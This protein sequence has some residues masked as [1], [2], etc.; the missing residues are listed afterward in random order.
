[1]RKHFRPLRQ[2]D[3]PTVEEWLAHT[4]YSEAEKQTIRDAPDIDVDALTDREV[5]KLISDFAS[6]IKMEWYG[7]VKAPR[8]IQGISPSLKKMLGPLIH[9]AELVCF[10]F[11]AFAKFV[12]V[13][14]RAKWLAEK[15]AQF[16]GCKLAQSDFSSFEQS[17]AELQLLAFEMPVFEHMFQHLDNYQ[18]IMKLLKMMEIGLATL[19]FKWMIVIVSAIRKSGTT[20]TSFS[21][22]MGNLLI[23]EFLGHHLG[24]GELVAAF[25]GDDGLFLYSS[26]RFPTPQD[27]A[28]LGFSVKLAIFDAPEEASFC[29]LVYDPTDLVNITDPVKYINNIGW[30]SHY[31]ARA[32]SGKILGLLRAKAMSLCVQ[33]PN[34]PILCEMSLWLLRATRSIDFKWVA[35]SRSAGWWER[36]VLKDL[37]TRFDYTPNVPSNTRSLMERAFGMPIEVQLQYEEWFRSRNTLE[38]IPLFHDVDPVHAYSAENFTRI[39]DVPALDNYPVFPEWGLLLDP[40]LNE[41][42]WKEEIRKG[43]LLET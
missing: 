34:C 3:I 13:A 7:E 29:G 2:E 41:R 14:N 19:V 27:Y 32:R 1:M 22:G 30:V 31:Y 11:E 37:P 25:E 6:F 40:M 4:S 21:N 26:G 8:T 23:H 20:N 17:W 9:A 43:L 39:S 24:L 35:R 10:K 15:F 42:A 18:K 16:L 38:R 5:K 33:Y 36:Q 12:P 28:D